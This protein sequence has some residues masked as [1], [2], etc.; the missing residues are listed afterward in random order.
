M[1]IQYNNKKQKQLKA[2]KKTLKENYENY[3]KKNLI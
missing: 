3:I 2:Y 1:I